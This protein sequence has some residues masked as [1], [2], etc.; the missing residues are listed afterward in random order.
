MFLAFTGSA[1]YKK[2][3]DTCKKAECVKANNQLVCWL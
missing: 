3:L 1:I 2:S